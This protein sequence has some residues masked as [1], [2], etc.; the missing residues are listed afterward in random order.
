VLVFCILGVSTQSKVLWRRDNGVKNK[1]ASCSVPLYK[2][3]S[4]LSLMYPIVDMLVNGLPGVT[5]HIQPFIIWLLLPVNE[6]RRNGAQL[7][8]ASITSSL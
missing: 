2:N 1:R 3:G 4:L 6:Q 8:T 5:T 7:C